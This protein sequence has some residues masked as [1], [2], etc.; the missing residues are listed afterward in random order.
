M[1]VSIL[2]KKYTVKYLCVF[3]LVGG[4]SS[5]FGQ[6]SYLDSDPYLDSANWHI[7]K[8]Q[9]TEALKDYN[10]ALEIS[11]DIADI[12]VYRGFAYHNLGQY[13]EALKDYNKALEFNPNFAVAYSSRGN[14]YHDLGQYAETLI[15]YTKALEINPD[16]AD[17]YFN[18]GVVYS[19]LFDFQEALKD[20][21][22]ALEF[23]PDISFAYAYRGVAKYMLGI[24]GCPDI[25]KA[26]SLGFTVTPAMKAICN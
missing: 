20:Y 18:R 3:L 24:D 6:N 9:Y 11:P 12:Y 4:I 23:N 8:G 26:E 5:A 16:D 14:V 25:K 19:S 2:E 21:N 17:V 7:E 10:K 1:E 15:D 22:K 13:D